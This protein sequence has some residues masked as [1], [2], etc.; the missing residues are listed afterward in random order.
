MS[1][2]L[3]LLLAVGLS[4]LLFAPGVFGDT[5]YLKK[6]GK[7]EGKLV[8]ETSTTYVFKIRGMGEQ[9]FKKSDVEKLVKSEGAE[10]IYARRAKALKKDDA[11]GHYELGLFCKENKLRKEARKCFKAAIA[12]DS[13]HAGARNEL[14][15]VNYH[16][17]W[18][19]KK[20]YKSLVA[21][22]EKKEGEIIAGL[23][24]ADD[25]VQDAA[26]RYMIFAPAGWETKKEEEKGVSI[27]GP[28]MGFAPVTITLTVLTNET[29]LDK[30]VAK[31]TK[32]LKEVEEGLAPIG[33]PTDTTLAG[34]AAKMLGFGW[35][36]ED[37]Q[38]W[39]VRMERRDVLMT[40]AG[41][42]FHVSVECADGY[43][44]KLK[45]IL[46]KVFGSVRILDKPMDF[47]AKEFGFG[48]AFPDDTYEKGDGK[49]PINIQF[50]NPNDNSKHTLHLTAPCV[51]VKLKEGMTAFIVN[52]GKKD[53]GKAVAPEAPL[54]AA[55]DE[56]RRHLQQDHGGWRR[57]PDRP[58]RG[59]AGRH[60]PRLLR[61]LHEGRPLLPGRLCH[62][63]Q[64][65]GQDV[66]EEGLRL[67][68]GG[69]QV[70]V[71]NLQPIRD[72]SLLCHC[73]SGKKF[74]DCH[75]KR[76]R[77]QSD[78]QTTEMTVFPRACPS[79]CRRR[80]SPTSLSGYVRSISGVILP[81]SRSSVRAARSSGFGPATGIILTCFT[82]IEVRN[83][84]STQLSFP[85]EE[86]YIP[87]G[88]RMRRQADNGRLA[89]RSRIRS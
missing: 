28:E 79:P 21:D 17:D 6:G 61:G 16:G 11:K 80:A 47:M 88:L 38:P 54:G 76:L 32:A 19:T 66:H 39:P 7:F 60:G 71:A 72:G 57:G 34:Q 29:D 18:V 20:K 42:S 84:F 89:T 40:S 82:T 75:G 50:N 78:P 23:K 35:T 31:T 10:D 24:L 1:R 58:V 44:E 13:N 53:D 62:P 4:L 81:D 83:T 26:L 30:L 45:P 14:G 68:H 22:M 56:R 87:S 69:V 70:P 67:V 55:V 63:H 85:A 37:L 64:P 74:R 12:A 3:L 27:E 36:S 77:R 59:D 5:I 65:D 51:S 41:G 86:T 46:D 2:S 15:Y 52:S 49:L 9:T 33:E 48:L 43:Y 73:G 25:P 8:K